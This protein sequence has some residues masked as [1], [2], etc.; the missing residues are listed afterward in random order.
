MALVGCVSGS[1][2]AVVP[3]FADANQETMTLR[4]TVEAIRFLNIN[5]AQGHY[6]FNVELVVAHEGIVE[7]QREQDQA[8]GTFHVRVHKVHWSELSADEQARLAPRGPQYGID[9]E[10]WQGY[11]VGRAVD[12]QVVGWG[13]GR[14]APARR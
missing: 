9:V 10:R 6:T 4:G 5:K 2:P 12:L 14:G 13:P 8:A 1:P 11:E 7:S 3:V